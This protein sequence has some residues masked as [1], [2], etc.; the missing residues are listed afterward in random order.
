LTP[1]SPGSFKDL[2]AHPPDVV[3]ID[4]SRSPAQGRDLGILLRRTRS[5]RAVPLV[6]V[7]GDPEKTER[8]RELLPDA[9]YTTWKRVRGSVTRALRLRSTNPVVPDSTFAAYAGTPLTKKLGIRPGSVVVLVGAP[10]G[11]EGRLG[12]LPEGAVLRRGARGRCDLVLWFARSRREVER[13]VARLGEFAGRDGLW[14]AWKKRA[15]GVASD[16]SQ[17]VVREIGLASGLVDYKVC[18]IDDT[19]SGLKFTQRKRGVHR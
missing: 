13:R 1:L 19:W 15:S 11:F 9:V 16:L 14:I 8:V 7:G 2:K 3:M 10:E 12:S 6:F 18:S 5:T 4:L 17:T